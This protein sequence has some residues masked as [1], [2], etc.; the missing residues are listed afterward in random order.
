M[1]KRRINRDMSWKPSKNQADSEDDDYERKSPVKTRKR[2]KVGE[3]LPEMGV[4]YVDSQVELVNSPSVR[5]RNTNRAPKTPRRKVTAKKK[6]SKEL[7]EEI[8]ERVDDIEL[9]KEIQIEEKI[10][11]EEK[12]E[13][14]DEQK[15]IVDNDIEEK[16]SNDDMMVTSPIRDPFK[17][18]L[19]NIVDDVDEGGVVERDDQ[20]ENQLEWSPLGTNFLERKEDVAFMSLSPEKPS[21]FSMLIRNLNPLSWFSK[22]DEKFQEKIPENFQEK[23]PSTHIQTTQISTPIST[24][25]MD[26]DNLNFQT[27]H[28]P[29]N[30]LELQ[31]Q[32]SS[33][34]YGVVWRALWRGSVVAAKIFRMKSVRTLPMFRK[35][36]TLLAKLRHPNIALYMGH[37]CEGN[38]VGIVMQYAEKGSLY[39]VLHRTCLLYT[40]PSPRDA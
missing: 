20:L 7:V 18:Q 38:K 6:Q 23:P 35:E 29:F 12:K 11:D 36:A 8:F 4:Q 17:T 40:S 16:K 2:R 10:I 31:Q 32:V 13:I 14:I 25:K 28:I 22:P 39:D 5:T 30:Q 19:V 26:E 21:R 1:K 15:D 9:E 37:F 34:T 33:G 3:I 24:S 27:F